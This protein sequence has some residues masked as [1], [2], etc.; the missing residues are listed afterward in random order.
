[1]ELRA[2]LDP[3]FEVSHVLNIL[4]LRP[5]SLG[6]FTRFTSCLS[7]LLQDIQLWSPKV[8]CSKDPNPLL[9]AGQGWSSNYLIAMV[10]VKGTI[11]PLSGVKMAQ[12]TQNW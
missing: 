10:P 5:M 12:I 9:G 4:L 11:G 7:I 3:S 8:T 6:S 2:C 1:M